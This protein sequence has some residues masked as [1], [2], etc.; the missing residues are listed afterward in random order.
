VALA[1]P[2]LAEADRDGEPVEDAV[3]REGVG[4][5]GCIALRVGAALGDGRA[6][7]EA[8]AVASLLPESAGEWEAEGETRGEAELPA[9]ALRETVAAGAPEATPAA[10]DEP[11]GA[12]AP[13]TLAAAVSQ[14]VAVAGPLRVGDTVGQ[15][16]EVGVSMGPPVPDSEGVAKGEQRG[17]AE[18]APVPEVPEPPAGPATNSAAAIDTVCVGAID[19]K[20]DLE[21]A[22]V[23]QAQGEW[24]VLREALPV[25]EGD[26]VGARAGE[27]AVVAPVRV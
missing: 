6:V 15:P 19:T 16:A 7:A 10:E 26:W 13:L 17:D 20:V 14:K 5:S 18:A 4:V 2:P 22:A 21:P 1:Q 25:A 24:L 23:A 3:S 11:V 8:R 9:E 27:C 12:A